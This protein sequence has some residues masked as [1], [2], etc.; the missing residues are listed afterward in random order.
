MP[1]LNL[2]D[3]ALMISILLMGILLGGIV[4]SHIVYF[5]VGL[6]NRFFQLLERVTPVLLHLRA[7]F[8]VFQFSMLGYDLTFTGALRIKSHRQC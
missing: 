2:C 3:L 5:P 7:R 8:R 6:F 1:K 4:Y